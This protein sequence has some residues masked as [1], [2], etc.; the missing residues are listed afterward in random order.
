MCYFLDKMKLILLF[1]FAIFLS[2]CTP[3][4]LPIDSTQLY[5]GYPCGENCPAFK[6]G[7]ETA[8]NRQFVSELDC[9]ALP[10][11]QSTGCQAY[12]F[13]YKRSLSGF[14]DFQMP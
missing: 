8:H 14:S 4:P 11:D 12:I 3:Q 6:N 5:Q 2:A 13:E 1:I 9:A 7:F 10:L